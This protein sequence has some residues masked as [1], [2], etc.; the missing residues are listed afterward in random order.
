[1]TLPSASL[2][3]AARAA[4][5]S[6]ADRTTPFIFN[7]WYVAAFTH[8]IDRTLRKRKILGRNLVLFRTT[9]GKPVALEDRCA[10]RSFPLSASKLD[11]DT[12]VCGYHGLRYDAAGDCIEVPSQAKCP[13]GIGVAHFPLVERGPLAWIWM[14]A[15]ELADPGKIPHQ[16]WLEAADW[17]RSQGY[18][19]LPAS[20]VSLHENL[21]DLTHLSYLHAASFGTADYA[22][23]PYE[24]VIENGRFVLNRQVVPT[25]L[26][27]VWAEPTG[28]R[29]N[30][31]ARIV[32]SEFVSPALHV[33]TVRFHDVALP[34]AE[35]PE[36][37]VRTAHIPTPETLTST[38]YFVVHG[39][40][41]ALSDPTVTRFMHEQ[42]F[43]AFAEDVVG[44]TAVEQTLAEAGE[45]PYEIS[46]ASDRASIAMRRYLKRRSDQEHFG[47]GRP[48]TEQVQQIDPVGVASLGGTRG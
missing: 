47:G 19:A 35:R 23:A 30:T 14:G 33:V 9:G 20:Y 11:G 3:R 27:P 24:A 21:M 46:V 22:S 48:D 42:L 45:D 15:P 32:S 2:I 16:P 18:F 13:R 34:A 44:L 5:R 29:G 12:I 17:E 25:K 40:D 8:E 10:H 6:M 31:A 4:S 39:R 38:H 1:M 36:F 26:P 7:E 41:F 28:I 37:E 43:T